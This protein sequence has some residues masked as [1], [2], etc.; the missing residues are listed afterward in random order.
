[1]L[2]TLLFDRGQPER[3]SNVSQGNIEIH[4]GDGCVVRPFDSLNGPE[5]YA[6][7]KGTGA[8]SVFQSEQAGVRRQAGTMQ[9]TRNSNGVGTWPQKRLEGI[10]GSVH[11]TPKL[12][13]TPRSG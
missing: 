1:L 12:K 4:C 5:L 8:L 11:A 10:C 13:A 2:D 6:N 9:T 3:D 7:S